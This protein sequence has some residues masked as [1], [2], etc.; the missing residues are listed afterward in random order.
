MSKYY[1]SISNNPT[2]K[3]IEQN[4]LYICAECLSMEEAKQNRDYLIS[5]WLDKVNKQK[6]YIK[7][8]SE[9]FIAILESEGKLDLTR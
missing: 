6:Q 7:P 3:A 5:E 4:T 9:V 2:E 1:I 8:L